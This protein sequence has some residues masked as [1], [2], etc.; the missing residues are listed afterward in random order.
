[1][2]YYAADLTDL[3][4]GL[5][6]PSAVRLSVCPIGAPSWKMKRDKETKVYVNVL[7]GRS[8]WVPV[9]S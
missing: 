4:T 1:M 8:N 2:F 5:A 9:F 6:R 7:H 3:I